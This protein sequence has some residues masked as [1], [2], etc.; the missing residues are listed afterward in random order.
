M[1]DPAT[2]RTP[3]ISPLVIGLVNNMPDAALRATERQFRRVLLAAGTARPV[4]IRRISLPGVKRAAWGN[5]IIAAEYEPFRGIGGTRLDGL[6]VTG[7]EPGRGRLE[8]EPYW[9]SFT[10]LVDFAVRQSIPTLWSCLAAHA[11]VRWL[12]GLERQPLGR[13]LTGV[14]DCERASPHP[15][16]RR[17]PP[18][19]T[20]PHSRYNDLAE[21]DLASAGYRVLSRS[22]EAGVDSFTR[23]GDDLFMFLQ[24]HPEYSADALLRE[25]RRDLLRVQRAERPAPA[26]MPQH[27]FTPAAEAAMPLEPAT[28][29]VRSPAWQQPALLFYT[30]WLAQVEAQG[31]L[32]M[33]RH[34]GRERRA[35]A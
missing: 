34:A 32:L 1:P 3:V 31:T 26:P 14:F 23:A 12:D 8:D 35:C 27:Y 28:D 22:P 17:L 30:G 29:S 9:N 13:K 21:A 15:V 2:A 10:A 33:Q 24:G 6:I 25:Y 11:A 5:D 4:H 16:T 19:W 18:R 20:V 7:T